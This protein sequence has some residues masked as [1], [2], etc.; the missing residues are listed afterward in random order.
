MIDW[1]LSGLLP[2]LTIGRLVEMAESWAWFVEISQDV[3]IWRCT[4]SPDFPASVSWHLWDE[5]HEPTLLCFHH[6]ILAVGLDNWSQ[7][8]ANENSEA[9][10][11][12]TPFLPYI[13]HVDSL[14]LQRWESNSPGHVTRHWGDYRLSSLQ[15]LA[16]LTEWV[17]SCSFP[18][19]PTWDPGQSC[20]SS[21]GMEDGRYVYGHR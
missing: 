16:I 15:P 20:S 21:G 19:P 1:L 12:N 6:D 14:F 8:S 11:Q 18:G 9:M 2:G 13:A 7:S 17:L 3:R 5:W 4:W 10:R